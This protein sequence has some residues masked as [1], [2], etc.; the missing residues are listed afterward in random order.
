MDFI[1]RGFELSV[2]LIDTGG[3]TT[4]KS[5]NLRATDYEDVQRDSDTIINKLD[6]VTDAII[7]SYKISEVFYRRESQYPEGYVR[8]TSRAQIN[9]TASPSN[10]KISLE[11]PA[12]KAELYLGQHGAS[13]RIIDITNEKLIAYTDIF[14]EDGLA[15]LQKTKYSL[16]RVNSGKYVSKK[17]NG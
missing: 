11:I 15:F 5:Y 8:N 1:S 2:S 13:A 16:I 4:S 9:C 10:K 6:E 14:R 17:S 7:V 12:P 3:K